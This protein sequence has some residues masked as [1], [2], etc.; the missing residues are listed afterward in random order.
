MRLHRTRQT[1]RSRTSSL[2][3]PRFCPG[4][5]NVLRLIPGTLPSLLRLPSAPTKWTNQFPNRNKLRHGIPLRSFSS[6]CPRIHWDTRLHPPRIRYRPARTVPARLLLRARKRCISQQF[7]SPGQAR[8]FAAGARR[9]LLRRRIK[10]ECT[11]ELERS[12]G[13]QIRSAGWNWWSSA[14]EQARIRPLP[15]SVT[16][17]RP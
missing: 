5:V 11:G 12:C 14:W 4:M 2:G 16:A 17:D 7:A 1:P 9:F 8:S 10:R 3:V 6:C 15:S 13:A